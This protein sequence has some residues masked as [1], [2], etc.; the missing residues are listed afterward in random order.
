MTRAPL[1]PELL[2]AHRALT[3]TPQVWLDVSRGLVTLE[4]AAS[5]VD[6]RESRALIER[7]K[8]LFAPP[9][10]EQ[11]RA[12]RARVL[13][14]AA[15][16]RRAWAPWLGAGGLA[17]AAAIALAL[18]MRPPALPP[19]LGAEYQVELSAEWS[20]VRGG[21]G[22]EAEHEWPVPAFRVD[23]SVGFTLRPSEAVAAAELEVVVLAQGEH[24]RDPRLASTRRLPT[25]TGTVRFSE[26]LDAL[27]L[28]PGGWE[29][30]FVVGRPGGVPTEL[31]PLRAAVAGGGESLYAV[32]HATIRVIDDDDGS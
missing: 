20:A 28:S 31:E 4:E 18:S 16:A 13:E 5:A 24:D 22:H 2:A 14:H 32:T 29:L 23:Q 25:T 27:G 8:Q 1:I 11:E 9:T 10:A 21:A 15:P 30:T 7:S 6:G 12:I 17:A 3:Q 26:R 19:P